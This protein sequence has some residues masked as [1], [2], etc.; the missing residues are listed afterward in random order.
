V[1]RQAAGMSEA[2]AT[3]NEVTTAEGTEAETSSSRR[4]PAEAN[5]CQRVFSGS[6]HFV[7]HDMHFVICPIC[8]ALCAMHYVLCTT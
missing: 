7:L 4:A 5:K 8:Y 6:M 3:V 2:D 1:E